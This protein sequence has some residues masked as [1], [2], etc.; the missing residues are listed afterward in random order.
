MSLQKTLLITG[1]S[2][3]FGRALAEA[4]LDA[5]HRVVGT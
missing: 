5:G 3:G 1:I 2:S 4:A